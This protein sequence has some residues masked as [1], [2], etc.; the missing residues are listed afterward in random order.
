MRDRGPNISRA[1]SSSGPVGAR[2]AERGEDRD[3]LVGHAGQGVERAPGR[4]AAGER[5]VEPLALA[6]VLP[7]G[8]DGLSPLGVY[9]HLER[10]LGLVR[11]EAERG[12]IFGGNGAERAQELRQ[13]ALTP[14]IA[15]ADLFQLR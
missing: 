14:E 2:E 9:E 13:L 11:G 4:P 15:N 5:E 10:L 6:L 1:N 3:D 12:S 8:P 7:L